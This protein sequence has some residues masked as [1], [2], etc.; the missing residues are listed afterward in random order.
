MRQISKA[1][2]QFENSHTKQRHKKELL[3]LV[4]D[5]YGSGFP[6][7]LLSNSVNGKVVAQRVSIKV[8]LH[9]H[10]D[11]THSANLLLKLA[12]GGQYCSKERLKVRQ[13]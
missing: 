12:A 13:L 6:P 7:P 5:C 9:M 4:N 3:D 2:K 1:V 8:R 11:C 10:W